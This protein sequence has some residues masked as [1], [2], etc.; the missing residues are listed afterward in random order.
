M[1]VRR[2]G[3]ANYLTPEQKRRQSSR[4][5]QPTLGLLKETT[6]P[7]LLGRHEHRR[8]AEEKLGRPLVKGEIVHHI[9]GNKHNNHP[10]NL[11]VMSQSEHAKEH[12]PK[13]MAARKAKHG[14]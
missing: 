5:A 12:W 11:E 2:Y 7:K 9:D 10:D 13:M 3:D 1:R 4:E 8:A 14:F 6:Y